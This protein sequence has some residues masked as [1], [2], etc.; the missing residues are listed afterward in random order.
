MYC[1][2]FLRIGYWWGT[3]DL[4]ISKVLDMHV[5]LQNVTRCHILAPFV[6]LRTVAVSVNRF[7]VAISHS[8][9]QKQ[10]A[11]LQHSVQLK[12]SWK[13]IA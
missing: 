9:F 8:K 10:P 13:Y 11:K 3:N 2:T 12:L 5:S 6:A 4:N 1:Q 7:A